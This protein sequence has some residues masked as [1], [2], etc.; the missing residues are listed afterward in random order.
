M[1]H[2]HFSNR[3]ERLAEAL[4]RR[5]AQAPAGG[6][7]FAADEVVVPSA[8]VTRRLILE[9][10][11]RHGI[12]ANVRFSY[13][14]QWLWR[15]GAALMP[16]LPAESPFDA[17]VLAW[18]IL[19]AFEDEAWASA[20]P[21]LADWLAGADAAMRHEL[22]RRVA[23]LFDQYLTYRPEWLQDW[24]EERCVDLGAASADAALDERWQAAL[25]RR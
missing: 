1:L 4:A 13:L 2:V 16:T 12:C 9:L 11:R 18:R 3:F 5:L 8:A 23:A 6:D 21:R 10:A 17:D 20:Q 7:P 14:A 25:W 24:V 22:A 15:Q 19:A